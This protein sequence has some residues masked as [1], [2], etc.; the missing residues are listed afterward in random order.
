MSTDRSMGALFYW[1]EKEFFGK[2]NPLFFQS[3]VFICVHLWLNVVRDARHAVALRHHRWPARADHDAGGVGRHGGRLAVGAFEEMNQPDRLP[4]RHV[5]AAI[6]EI[7]VN[8]RL[9]R[10]AIVLPIERLHPAHRLGAWNL[11]AL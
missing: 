10:E 3:S 2:T 6:D 9:R 1:M 11:V 7:L 4:G 8:P 5:G